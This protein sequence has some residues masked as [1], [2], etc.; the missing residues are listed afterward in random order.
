MLLGRLQ[1]KFID[2]FKKKQQ[3]NIEFSKRNLAEIDNK[4]I[5]HNEM[6]ETNRK[7]L[8]IIRSK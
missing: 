1:K 8:S 7:K 5:Y 6:K 4:K 2:E 3:K